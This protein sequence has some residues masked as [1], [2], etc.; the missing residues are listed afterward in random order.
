MRSLVICITPFEEYPKSNTGHPEYPPTLGFS[1]QKNSDNVCV[2]ARL[3][4]TNPD[5]AYERNVNGE[6]EPSVPKP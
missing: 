2:S 1:K 5:E 3:S 6:K 4:V